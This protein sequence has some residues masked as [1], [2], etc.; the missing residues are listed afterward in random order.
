VRYL[1]IARR[2][3]IYERKYTSAVQRSLKLQIAPVI[4]QLETYK[5]AEIEVYLDPEPIKKVFGRL[6]TETGKDF[7]QVTHKELTGK[8][9]KDVLIDVWQ[10]E[11][12][13]F[14][15]QYGGERILSIT[16][17]SK[18]IAIR[19]LRELAETYV[20]PEG[21]GIEETSRL[22]QRKFRESYLKTTLARARVIAQTEV[23][24]ASN[25]GSHVGA[26]EAGASVKIWQTSGITSPDGKERH[27]AYPGLH[28]QE[29]AM[30][31][32]FDVGGYPAD[33][34]GDPT[35]PAGEVVNCKCAEVYK[36]L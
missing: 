11:M 12:I 19:I 21:L 28:G 13:A 30:D 3:K 25:K 18:E 27:V 32:K 16:G 26:L 1:A 15:T 29:R 10:Q 35:L 2:R 6:Y 4:K 34:P 24:T 7:A 9:R 17:S 22:F 5:P 14:I 23:L 33:W 31:E 20:I 36:I 8:S